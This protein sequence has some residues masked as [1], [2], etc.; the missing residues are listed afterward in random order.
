VQRLSFEPDDEML[1]AGREMNLFSKLGQDLLED[2]AQP[3]HNMPARRIDLREVSNAR[4][5]VRVPR[6]SKAV[7]GC[8]PRVRIECDSKVPGVRQHACGA[9]LQPRVRTDV[10]EELSG[11]RPIRQAFHFCVL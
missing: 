5:R 9:N 3:R 10:E 6:L 11:G 4:L 2:T 7:R 1:S 8:A